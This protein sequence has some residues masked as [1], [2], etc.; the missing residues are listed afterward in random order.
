MLWFDSEPKLKSHGLGR[1][2]LFMIHDKNMSFDSLPWRICLDAPANPFNVVRNRLARMDLAIRDLHPLLHLVACFYSK[3]KPTKKFIIALKMTFTLFRN[4][5]VIE[6]ANG[7]RVKHVGFNFKCPD[8]LNFGSWVLLKSTCKY[9]SYCTII[10]GFPFT[11]E[12]HSKY[13]AF[14]TATCVAHLS[15]GML[16]TPKAQGGPRSDTRD[17]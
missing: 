6:F 7:V 10:F 5:S 3:C 16:E 13:I 11:C 2:L 12:C 8:I 9:T 14:S 15:K 4:C 17:L 1:L